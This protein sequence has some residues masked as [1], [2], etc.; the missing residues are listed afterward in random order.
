MTIDQL[1]K[2]ARFRSA[3]A[4]YNAFSREGYDPEELPNAPKDVI[5]KC[6]DAAEK[7]ATEYLEAK[8]VLKNGKP[9]FADNSA[10][11]TAVLDGSPITRE[12]N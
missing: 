11:W 3:V 10:N 4:F 8:G 6:F 5:I 2:E 12:T 1:F 9:I 7:K